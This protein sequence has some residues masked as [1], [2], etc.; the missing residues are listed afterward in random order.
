MGPDSGNVRCE[1][2]GGS[3]VRV[4]PLLDKWAYYWRHAV[5]SL[6]E[7]LGSGRHVARLSLER[8]TAEQQ[9]VLKRSP[10]GPAWEACVASSKHPK[11]WLS[12]WLV[13]V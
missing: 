1:V 9:R 11:L 4:V 10:S 3:V 7:G 6:V 13:G 5:V 2:D 12:Y 8:P